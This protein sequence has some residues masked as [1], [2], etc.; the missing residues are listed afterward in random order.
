MVFQ[1][2]ERVWDQFYHIGE[3]ED[4]PFELARIAYH[5]NTSYYSRAMDWYLASL[6]MFGEHYITFYNL[7]LVRYGLKEYRTAKENLMM[8][9]ELNDRYEPA[10]ELLKELLDAEE[11]AAAPKQS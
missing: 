6:E 3:D 10:H 2:L 7:A 1:A 8:S 4:I 9:M 5:L 11:Q